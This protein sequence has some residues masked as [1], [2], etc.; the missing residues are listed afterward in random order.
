[1]RHQPRSLNAIKR[2]A[3]SRP[4]PSWFWVYA[5]PFILPKLLTAGS[6]VQEDKGDAWQIDSESWEQKLA[7]HARTRHESLWSVHAPLLRTAHFGREIV[8]QD[9]R[10][11]IGIDEF[12]TPAVEFPKHLLILELLE[13]FA[14]LHPSF[15]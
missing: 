12:P 1:L 14:R 7:P 13:R 15:D 3:R 8:V 6:V 10:E 4:S 2:F 5:T 9:F 11:T